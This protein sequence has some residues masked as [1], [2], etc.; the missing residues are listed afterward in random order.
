[1]NAMKYRGYFGT[2]EYS[3]ADHR[4]LSHHLVS[5]WQRVL[6]KLLEIQ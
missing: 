1:M 6:E 4:S 2:V 5:P 3:T